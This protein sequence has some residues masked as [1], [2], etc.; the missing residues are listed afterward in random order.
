MCCQRPNLSR[1]GVGAK[2]FG[3]RT[4]MKVEM[5]DRLVEPNSSHAVSNLKQ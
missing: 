3:E 5:E 4:G 1:M 2:A